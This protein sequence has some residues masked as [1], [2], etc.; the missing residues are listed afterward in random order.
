MNSSVAMDTDSMGASPSD[1]SE[2]PIAHAWVAIGAFVFITIAG[3]FGAARLMNYLYPA[4]A[5]ILMLF[6]Y[7]RYPLLFH[8]L[9]WWL[10]FLTPF[11]RRVVD[12]K[13]S[14]TDPSPIL[15]AP[16]LSGVVIL[17]GF[18]KNFPK[19]ILQDAFPF[20]IS[21]LAVAYGACMGYLNDVATNKL[22]LAVLAWISPILYGFYIYMNWRRYADFRRNFEKNMLWGVLVMGVYGI[23]QY[24]TLPEWDRLW[25]INTGITAA[26]N[27]FPQEFRVWSTMNSGEPFSAVMATALILNFNARGSIAIASS[28]SG[29]I[30]LLL[31]LVRSAWLGWLGGIILLFSVSNSIFQR[32]I[33]TMAVAIVTIL[34]PLVLT[35]SFAESLSTRFSTLSDLEN[36]NSASGRLS[37]YGILDEL[38]SNILGRGINGTSMDSSLLSLVSELGP[39]GAVP[40]AFGLLVLI[41]IAWKSSRKFS[42]ESSKLMLAATFTCVVRLP[43]NNALT[44]ISGLLLWG[45][46][47]F[48]VAGAKYS[49]YHAMKNDSLVRE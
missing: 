36:D 15:L 26:G 35:S 1:R 10:Y 13:T 20:A 34:L 41:I 38:F 7:H 2:H 21:A 22:I 25:L 43:V 39:L 8:G 6:L 12:Y 47:S 4:S 40:Y 17:P 18:L 16:V 33:I 19:A 3:M 49:Q 9:V 44:G 14:F 11:I 45:C 23:W 5:F 24:F 28:V 29:Y 42:G 48:A 30:A 32:K 27:P 37:S 31:T 46:L